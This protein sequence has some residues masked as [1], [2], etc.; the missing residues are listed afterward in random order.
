[1]SSDTSITLRELQS[2]AEQ[3]V[4]RY[5]NVERM[6]CLHSTLHV[7]QEAM[8]EFD[9]INY[10]HP[11]IIK[12]S[13]GILAGL[14]SSHGPCGIVLAGAISLS[15]K[16]GTEDPKDTITVSKT[17]MRARDWYF[18]FR[19]EFGSCD[20]VDISEVEDWFDNESVAKYSKYKKNLCNAIMIKSVRK[21][22][23]L[24]TMEDFVC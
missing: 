18:W 4:D 5:W 23:D 24:I 14:W 16:Y 20:C 17:G 21:I 19:E 10:I 22:V 6:V 12:A 7:I 8:K 11:I 2:I 1:M 15:L 9:D 3:A 13:N